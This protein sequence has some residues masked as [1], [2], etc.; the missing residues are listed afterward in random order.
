MVWRSSPTSV[1]LQISLWF[2]IFKVFCSKMTSQKKSFFFIKNS[3]GEFCYEEFKV[4]FKNCLG[5]F[6]KVCSFANQSFVFDFWRF[7][8]M[9]SQKKCHKKIVSENSHIKSQKLSLKVVWTSYEGMKV[10]SFANQSLIFNFWVFV[11]FVFKL[12]LFSKY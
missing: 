2:L 6:P 3:F 5:V 7:F 10:C 11:Y 1:V 8:L 4:V 9:T 12:K